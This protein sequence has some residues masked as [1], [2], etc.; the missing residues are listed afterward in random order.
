MPTRG[1]KGAAYVPAKKNDFTPRKGYVTIRGDT[2][3]PPGFQAFQIVRIVLKREVEI[4][5]WGTLEA[6]IKRKAKQAPLI[7][8]IHRKTDKG[9]GKK[10]AVLDDEDVARER[11][12]EETPIRCEREVRRLR[13]VLNY[14]LTHELVRADAKL[15]CETDGN[16]G[17]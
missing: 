5:V 10:G 3:Q 14:R 9:L 2:D 15:R 16:L 12:D 13:D 1:Q 4:H 17:A 11:S 8:V 7:K 6:W